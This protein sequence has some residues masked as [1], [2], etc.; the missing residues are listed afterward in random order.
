MDKEH[1]DEFDEE[2]LLD[3][4]EFDTV[5]MTDEDGLDEEFVI[6]DRASLNGVNYLLVVK[7]EYMDDDEP[8]A[9]ILKQVGDDDDELT[10]ERLEDG[11]EFEA[12]AELFEE[13]E[14]YDL[15]LDD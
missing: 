2:I 1:M 14:E 3:D 9:E 11:D 4:E 12:A 15:E 6:I 7:S 5:T 13:N 10:Y 8:E